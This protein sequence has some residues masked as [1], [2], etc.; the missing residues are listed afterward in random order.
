MISYHLGGP[1]VSTWHLVGMERAPSLHLGL[2]LHRA[3]FIVRCAMVWV[4]LSLPV[5]HMVFEW[6]DYSFLF[7]H[8]CIPRAQLILDLY[9][10]F[11]VNKWMDRTKLH[12]VL[13][14]SCPPLRFVTGIGFLWSVRPEKCHSLSPPGSLTFWWHFSRLQ[15]NADIR[16]AVPSLSSFISSYP[17]HSAGSP[18]RWCSCAP[19]GRLGNLPTKGMQVALGQLGRGCPLVRVGDDCGHAV[20]AVV[21]GNPRFGT[22]P[23][24]AIPWATYWNFLRESKK[25][26]R[27]NEM[28]LVGILSRREK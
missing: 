8:F 13:C 16:C 2:L 10:H 5:G 17:H 18:S 23:W 25:K 15:W 4:T 14:F 20:E 19:G 28:F 27:Q 22:L 1:P 21:M 24:Y 3:L 7:V 9:Q 11:W 26:G 6:K 12:K